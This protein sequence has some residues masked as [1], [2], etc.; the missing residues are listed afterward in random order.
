MRR[1]GHGSAGSITSRPYG[2]LDQADLLPALP[3]LSGRL[4][5]TANVPRA[6]D[7]RLCGLRSGRV[8]DHSQLQATVGLRW[9]RDEKDSPMVASIIRPTGDVISVVAQRNDSWDSMTYLASLN[10]NW[11]DEI[12]TY[13]S[14]S[15]GFKS[16][17]VQQ[18]ANLAV[19]TT[20]YDPE[21]VAQTE[22]GLKSE[23]F[24]GR[25]RLNLS[26]FHLKYDD[27]QVN[28]LRFFGTTPI[29]LISNAA[30]AKVVGVD[31]Q[32][33]ALLSESLT[34]T[35]ADSY[36]PTAKIE[37]F[38][39]LGGFPSIEGFRMPRSPKNSV[40]ASLDFAKTLTNEIDLSLGLRTRTEAIS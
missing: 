37:G 26:G 32:L 2:G 28:N 16:G 40:T 25:V 33:E 27:L 23:L 30:G 8:R 7:G 4:G 14:Y 18:A 3:L 20:Y 24:R 13:V 15:T 21:T 22:I 38:S 31:L 10:Y 35:L 36:L 19:A 9:S 17:G 34:L 5:R 39:S 29:Q 12:M 11:T 6:D 1:C